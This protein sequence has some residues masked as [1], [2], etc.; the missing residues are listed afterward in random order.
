MDLCNLFRCGKLL[1]RVVPGDYDEYESMK[2]EPEMGI[3]GGSRS[4]GIASGNLLLSFGIKSLLYIFTRKHVC[5]LLFSAR[6]YF[7]LKTFIINIYLLY[8][9]VCLLTCFLC[10]ANVYHPIHPHSHAPMHSS[11]TI[12]VKI[13]TLIQNSLHMY[14]QF[15]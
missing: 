9:V 3:G 4:F 8:N 5:V 2:D 13:Q 7:L 12:N 10:F 1:K 15:V 11:I 14:T 6:I